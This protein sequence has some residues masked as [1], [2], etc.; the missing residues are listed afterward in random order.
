MSW[1]GTGKYVVGSLKNV[2]YVLLFNAMQCYVFVMP[3]YSSKVNL[4][5]S[6]KSVGL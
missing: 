1:N 4:L 2:R 3:W 6:L 5:N